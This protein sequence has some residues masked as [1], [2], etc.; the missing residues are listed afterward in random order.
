MLGYLNLILTLTFIYPAIFV[1]RGLLSA[2]TCSFSYSAVAGYAIFGESIKLAD[3]NILE[4]LSYGLPSLVAW[5][6]IVLHVF[7]AISIINCPILLQAEALFGLPMPVENQRK[8]VSDA[9]D[10]D[11]EDGDMLAAKDTTDEKDTESPINL[12]TLTWKQTLS[13][14][15]IRG[16]ILLSQ[17][18][19]A[20][21]SKSFLL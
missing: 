8:N 4:R 16:F 18:F 5:L 20:M 6:L 7:F 2:Y 1:S 11:M 10:K 12:S 17:F 15:A 13:S 14:I 21:L 3:G 19:L 9:I